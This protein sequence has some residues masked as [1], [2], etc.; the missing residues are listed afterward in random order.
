MP[1]KNNDD[2]ADNGPTI[3]SDERSIPG[4]YTKVF[5]KRPIFFSGST[6]GVEPHTFSSTGEIFRDYRTF[7]REKE[8]IDSDELKELSKAYN[9]FIIWAFKFD[10]K[11]NRHKL[12]SA[13]IITILVLV[14]PLGGIVF[15]ALQLRKA[16]ST[17]DLSSLNTDVAI[18]MAGKVTISS[19]IV[20]G[21]VLVISIVFFYF[22]LK[23]A[24]EKPV[25]NIYEK[26]ISPPT[27]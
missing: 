5:W 16:L 18:E 2:V 15:A 22:Y 1:E 19:S 10:K 6:I 27:S 11:A 7:L 24:Y 4:K 8:E 3:L 26:E 13:W 12:I 17:G 9:D 23:F 25:I 20:G 14:L 21:V